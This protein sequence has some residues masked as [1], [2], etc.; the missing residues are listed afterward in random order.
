M[1]KSYEVAIEGDRITWLGEKPN[2]QTTRAII[3]IAEENKVTQIKRRSPS[4]A[5]AGKGR[6]L[7]DIVSPIVDEEDWEC[8]K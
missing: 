4:K 8:L 3:V 6:T 5:I 7:G 2:F 1:L